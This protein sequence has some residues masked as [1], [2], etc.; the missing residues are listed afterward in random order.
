MLK[1]RLLGQSMIS[2]PDAAAA[3][4]IGSIHSAAPLIREL[5]LSG[6]GIVPRDAPDCVSPEVGPWMAARRKLT[7]EVFA[8]MPSELSAWFVRLVALSRDVDGLPDSDGASNE[9]A[10]AR[11]ACGRRQSPSGSSPAR[12]TSSR[13]ESVCAERAANCGRPIC[14]RAW[15]ASGRWS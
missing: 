7:T 11:V 4:G 15:L 3:C 13:L 14:A 10:D 2:V 12:V 1:R 6:L 9:V 5:V 8:S